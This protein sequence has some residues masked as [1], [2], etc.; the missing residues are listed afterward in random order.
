MEKAVTNVM[1]VAM[2]TIK[3]VETRPAF[4]T[5]QPNRRYIIAPKMVKIDG[6]NTPSKVPYF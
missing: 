6:V 5:T 2:K 4:P 3:R 1:E